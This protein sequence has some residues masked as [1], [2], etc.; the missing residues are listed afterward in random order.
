MISNDI[1]VEQSLAKLSPERPNPI[2]D[3]NRCRDSQPNIRQSLG[4]PI[5]DGDEV[6]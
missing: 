2:N 1:F 5:S 4:K 3:G 6:M